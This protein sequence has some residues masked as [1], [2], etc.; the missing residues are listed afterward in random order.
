MRGKNKKWDGVDCRESCGNYHLQ[1]RQCSRELRLG[2]C[3]CEIHADW[4]ARVA[5]FL[6]Y[7]RSIRLIFIHEREKDCFVGRF[8]MR[9]RHTGSR[10]HSFLFFFSFL[11]RPQLERHNSTTPTLKVI[12]V[13]YQS[14]YCC[15]LSLSLFPSLSVCTCENFRQLIY[16]PTGKLYDIA[17]LGSH[18]Q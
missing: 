17:P 18:Q 6:N 3:S 8:L 1:W 11:H 7:N 16:S 14:T 10:L 13:W 9:T 2:T 5:A 12:S 15:W 4:C